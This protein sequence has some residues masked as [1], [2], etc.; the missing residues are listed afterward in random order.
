MQ[1]QRQLPLSAPGEP[2]VGAEGETTAPLPP[3]V[4]R[5]G[6]AP[7]AAATHAS[8]RHTWLVQSGSE[9]RGVGGAQGR[10]GTDGRTLAPRRSFLSREAYLHLLEVFSDVTSG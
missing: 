7:C 6:P 8:W 1:R 3:P 9:D 2:A 4:A 10:R 5:R